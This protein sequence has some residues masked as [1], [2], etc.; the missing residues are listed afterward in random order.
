M[1]V[2]AGLL[3]AECLEAVEELGLAWIVADHSFLAGVSER[4]RGRGQPVPEAQ[5]LH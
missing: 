5:R 3:Q 2:L 1:R 4:S